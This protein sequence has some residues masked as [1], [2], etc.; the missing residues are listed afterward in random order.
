MGKRVRGSRV[1]PT[2]KK[3]KTRSQWTK[4]PPGDCGERLPGTR[5]DFQ[6]PNPPYCELIHRPYTFQDEHGIH[7]YQVDE[8]KPFAERLREGGESNVICWTLRPIVRRTRKKN[9]IVDSSSSPSQAQ[10]QLPRLGQTLHNLFCLDDGYYYTAKVSQDYHL[11]K[12]A[13]GWVI[14]S[15]VQRK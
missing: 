8:D 4:R 5:Y 9:D 13:T 7:Y 11:P 2:K 15:Q 14:L 1:N 10:P 3:K 6:V 12:H